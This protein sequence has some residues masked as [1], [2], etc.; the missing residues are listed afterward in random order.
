MIH[1][2]IVGR[3][4]VGK[5]YLTE[6]LRKRGM[7]VVKS[8]ATRPKRFETE[9][10]HIFITPEEAANITD[11]VATTTINGY[12]YFATAS[13]VDATDIYIIDPKGLQELTANM[14]DAAFYLV[15][16]EADSTM[17]R[18]THA[19]ARAEDKIKE[20]TVFDQRNEAEDEMFT[21]FENTLR[22]IYQ[23]NIPENIVGIDIFENTYDKDA[24]EHFADTIAGHK[25]FHNMMASIIQEGLEL[26]IVSSADGNPDKI[27]V[28]KKDGSENAVSIDRFTEIVSGNPHGMSD[29]MKAYI[30]KSNRFADLKTNF[31]ESTGE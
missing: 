1:Y 22:H 14:P 11:K 3:T 27:K 24:A 18:K 15:Y 6:L 13:Q 19:V 12:E 17:T 31:T 25:E 23:A 21:E 7:S 10:S 8:Y 20:E 30:Y 28:V 9:D 16:V 5:D 4:G 26:G 29:F 2:L